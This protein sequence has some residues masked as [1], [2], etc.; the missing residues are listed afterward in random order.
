M[1]FE[2]WEPY[3]IDILRDFGYSRAKDEQAAEVLAKLLEGKEKAL[4]ESF[5]SLLSGKEVF[6]FGGAGPVDISG[7]SED[8]EAVRIAADGATSYL[9][10]RG[11]VPDIIVTDM[12]GHVPDQLEASRRGAVVVIHAHGDNIPA[13]EKW[14]PRFEGSVI[15]TTQA[16]PLETIHNFGGFTDGDRAVFLAKHF[17]A[18]KVRLFGFDFETVGKK[19]GMDAE[20]KLRKLSWARK[21]LEGLGEDLIY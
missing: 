17:G 4:L 8:R 18:V 10:E 9:L 16:K 3:Y 21:L 1:E 19:D 15:G 14:V 20:V 7:I 11:R 12:D 13:L 2:R 6:V 5:S